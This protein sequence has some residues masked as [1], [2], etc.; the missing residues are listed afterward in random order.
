MFKIA[1]LSLNYVY[2]TT[3]TLKIRIQEKGICGINLKIKTKDGLNKKY[4]IIYFIRFVYT[5]Y[6]N[7][8]ILV[9]LLRSIS[10]IKPSMNL[11]PKSAPMFNFY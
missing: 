5:S 3:F 8:M 4:L 2:T 11:N 10:I 9:R 7:C 6:I 1:N